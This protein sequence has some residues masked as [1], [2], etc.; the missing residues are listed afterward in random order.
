LKGIVELVKP[1]LSYMPVYMQTMLISYNWRAVFRQNDGCTDSEWSR[2][3][4]RHHLRI[5]GDSVHVPWIAYCRLL[6]NMLTAQ[7]CV[8]VGLGRLL[9]S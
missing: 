3:V 5:Y 2:K 1:F 4:A 7:F 6:R 8:M 9:L